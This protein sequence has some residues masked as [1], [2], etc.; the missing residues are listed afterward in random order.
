MEVMIKLIL[1]C[2]LGG[3]AVMDCKRKQVS[4]LL[5]GVA[6]G[7]VIINYI[8]Y[9]PIAIVSL[10]GGILVGVAL[11]GVSYITRQK[12]GIGDGL[13]V[14]ILGAY[15]GFERVGI[16]LLYALTLSAI[17]SGLLLV[18]KKV[19]KDYVIAFVPFIFIGYLGV[20]IHG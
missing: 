16:L 7:I 14:I 1:T 12:I 11:V 10:I 3:I 19:K 4:N 13:L 2:L 5:L 20:W 15:L 9:R 17:W 18:I 6:A 8:L